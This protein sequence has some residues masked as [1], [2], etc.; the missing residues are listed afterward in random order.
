MKNLQ[1]VKGRQLLEQFSE[2]IK[3]HIFPIAGTINDCYNQFPKQDANKLCTKTFWQYFVKSELMVP[4]NIMVCDEDPECDINNYVFGT[5][6]IET[7]LLFRIS[8]QETIQITISIGTLD[9]LVEYRKCINNIWQTVDNSYVSVE[10]TH[11]AKVVNNRVCYMSIQD[12]CE[13]HNSNK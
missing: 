8:A 1:T 6:D 7:I 4:W 2:V 9:A 11:T 13:T 12:H 5:H 10:V 3:G